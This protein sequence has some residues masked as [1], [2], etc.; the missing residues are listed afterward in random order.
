M[1][2]LA[3]ARSHRSKPRRRLSRSAVVLLC[4]SLELASACLNPAISDEAPISQGVS[5][6]EAY[7]DETFD[8][9]VE[10]ADE[11]PEAR[12]TPEAPPERPRGDTRTRGTR[13]R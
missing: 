4:G 7:D 1:R 11:A 12:P 9:G 10:A 3:P 8:A 2:E 5:V 6:L 13:R